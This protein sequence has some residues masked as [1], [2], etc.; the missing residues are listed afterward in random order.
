M[1]EIDKWGHPVERVRPERPPQPRPLTPA[2]IQE[3]IRV[4]VAYTRREPDE[5]MVQVWAAQSVIGRWTFQE[6]VHAIH[7]WGANRG[8][9]DFLEPGDVTRL[10]RAS[11]Q[12]Q[13]MR[14]EAARAQAPV[15]HASAARIRQ[16]MGELAEQL[17][18]SEEPRARE[19]FALR[20]PCPHC[21]AGVG[22]RCTN[23]GSG[24]PLSTQPCHPSRADALAA[25]LRGVTHGE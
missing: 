14:E 18:W 3:L 12:D 10:I 13:A 9:S 4:V 15:D 20:V 23:P 8:P 7:L 22:A 1:T 17:G 6:A 5:A 2:E 25:Q 19:G 21:G 16:V 24:R 11:R